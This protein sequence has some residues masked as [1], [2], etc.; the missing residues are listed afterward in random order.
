MLQDLYVFSYSVQIFCIMTLFSWFYHA[1]C[2]SG[3]WY[4]PWV[5]CFSFL[6][7]LTN[8][9]FAFFSQHCK[10]M[11]QNLLQA[12]CTFIVD[13]VMLSCFKIWNPSNLRSVT[14]KHYYFP[15]DIICFPVSWIMQWMNF[16]S[17]VDE[18][19]DCKHIKM[20]ENNNLQCLIKQ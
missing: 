5:S 13:M 17:F 6:S 7:V 1:F 10:N 2:Y 9:P 16:I 19:Q 3:E 14:F 4:G 18:R 11:F 12:V 8:S 20:R 15:V